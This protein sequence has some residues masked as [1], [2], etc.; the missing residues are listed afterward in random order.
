MQRL[1]Q[2]DQQLELLLAVPEEV[3]SNKLQ[4]LLSQRELLL[5][6]LMAE[7]ESLDKRLWQQAI[8]RTSV[9]LERIRHHRDRS[10]NQVQ[11]LQHGQRSMQVY[12][13][14]R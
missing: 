4:A 14:F 2:I 10:A 13:K 1:D 6:Q 12:N 8:E 7:P 5:Q 11:R 3:D 9:L